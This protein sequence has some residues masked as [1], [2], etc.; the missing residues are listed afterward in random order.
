LLKHGEVG[1]EEV[2]VPAVLVAQTE[3][4]VEEVEEVHIEL[5]HITYRILVVLEQILR[6]L[7]LLAV[8]EP[9]QPLTGLL[10]EM[11]QEEAILPSEDF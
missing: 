8:P 2:L 9:L 3:L 4:E 6:L 10:V 5:L 1:V 7:Q 11:E